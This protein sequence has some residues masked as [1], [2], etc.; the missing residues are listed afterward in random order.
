MAAEHLPSIEPVAA[1]P[2]HDAAFRAGDAARVAGY[3]DT[4]LARRGSHN[5]DGIRSPYIF[6]NIT[7]APLNLITADRYAAPKM[8][9]I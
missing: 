6:V 1:E 4:V 8:T 5:M 2:G 9:T 3:V 7:Y